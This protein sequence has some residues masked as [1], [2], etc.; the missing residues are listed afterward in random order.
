MKILKIFFILFTTFE[1]SKVNTLKEQ[2][3]N[4]KRQLMLK[5]V[6]VGG[7]AAMIYY[8]LK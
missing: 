5:F 4:N 3:S 6:P 1:C 2:D 7:A 8:G